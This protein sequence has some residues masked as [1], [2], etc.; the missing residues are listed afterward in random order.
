MGL[1]FSCSGTFAPSRVNPY[2][3]DKSALLRRFISRTRGMRS[4]RALEI[5][6]Q[7]GIG[8][9]TAHRAYQSL[10]KT[11]THRAAAAD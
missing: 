11:L 2:N 4:V 1:W 10:S 9:G 8:V 6:K 7:L 3:T 5:A